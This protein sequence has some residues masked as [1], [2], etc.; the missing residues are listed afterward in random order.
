MQNVNHALVFVFKSDWFQHQ[1]IPLHIWKIY[2]RVLSSFV[3][4]NVRKWALANL[5]LELVPVDARIM[6][7]YLGLFFGLKP[8]LETNIMDKLNSTSALA[9][10]QQRVVSIMLSIP[11]KSALGNV[12]AAFVT[13]INLLVFLFFLNLEFGFILVLLKRIPW[14]KRSFFR[15]FWFDL[16]LYAL[17]FFF[18]LQVV[19]IHQR[20]FNFFLLSFCFFLNYILNLHM[21]P[22]KTE[23]I[24][25]NFFDLSLVWGIMAVIIWMVASRISVSKRKALVGECFVSINF[26]NRSVGFSR[27]AVVPFYKLINQ[28]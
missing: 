8:A 27:S 14:S 7:A 1:M 13:L 6:N 24:A 5:A 9:N 10:L 3:D 22:T 23:I 2:Q 16:F 12:F 4:K 28:G 11:A 18:Y 20:T 15:S 17:N 25:E 19:I 26:L 21:S